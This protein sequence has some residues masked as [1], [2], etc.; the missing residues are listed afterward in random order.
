[1]SDI[2]KLP[3]P[4]TPIRRTCSVMPSESIEDRALREAREQARVLNAYAAA[5][6]LRERLLRED[7]GGPR[8]VQ[9]EP[10]KTA[11][12]KEKVE[13]KSDEVRASVLKSAQRK[14]DDP[15]KYPAMTPQEL[16]AVV[17]VGRSS[18][19]EH[20]KLDRYPTGNRTKLWTTKSVK[21][22]LNSP[23]D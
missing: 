10:A 8:D 5:D 14:L 2:P 13:R 4:I 11:P 19:Y 12:P 18:S 20:P 1:M 16:R 9:P 21:A 3:R 6:R 15:D 23:P 7:P 22:L 17:P